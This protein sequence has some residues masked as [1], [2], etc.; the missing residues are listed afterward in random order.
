MSQTTATK[1]SMVTATTVDDVLNL[2]EKK[3]AWFGIPTLTVQSVRV[4]SDTMV[5][6]VLFD[7]KT[8][9]EFNKNFVITIEENV[10][11]AVTTHQIAA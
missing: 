1:S 6:A 3:I 5:K 2:L 11:S 8:D 9:Q 10:F 7:T 4:V